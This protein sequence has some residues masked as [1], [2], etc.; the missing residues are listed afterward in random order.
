MQHKGRQNNKY[1][2]I[3]TIILSDFIIQNIN[4]NP[5]CFIACAV[6]RTAKERC[7]LETIKLEK[8]IKI[9]YLGLNVE[10]KQQRN[11]QIPPYSNEMK[12]SY[13]SLKTIMEIN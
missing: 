9:N 2:K 5:K 13:S 11:F 10:K 6:Q 7:K 1:T 8:F 12:T 4:L 3:T